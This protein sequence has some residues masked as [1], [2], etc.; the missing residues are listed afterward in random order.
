MTTHFFHQ[1]LTEGE[2][3][4]GAL[5]EVVYFAETLKNGSGS[6]GRNTDAGI[7]HIELYKIL[8]IEE[9]EMNLSSRGKLYSIAEQVTY[10]LYR[11]VPV[12][13]NKCI[14]VSAIQNQFYVCLGFVTI[15]LFSLQSDI[16]YLD[17]LN[18]EFKRVGFQAG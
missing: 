7:S 5:N 11:P 3:Q 17:R 1:H 16:P 14:G 18:V 10:D 13:G 2:S 4:S 15:L 12:C 6:F 9:T 8:F